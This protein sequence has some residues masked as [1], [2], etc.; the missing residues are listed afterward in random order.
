MSDFYNR[1]KPYTD[2]MP[3]KKQENVCR[4]IGD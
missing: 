1:A 4:I 2:Y 3:I